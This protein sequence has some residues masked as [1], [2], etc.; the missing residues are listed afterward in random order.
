MR[1]AC[2]HACSSPSADPGGTKH[3]HTHTHPSL[4][5]EPACNPWVPTRRPDAA[6]RTGRAARRQASRTF[7][8]SR[9]ATPPGSNENTERNTRQ[10]PF[11]EGS[12]NRTRK[13]C[14]SS[15]C[16]G[17]RAEPGEAGQRGDAQSRC[18][19]TAGSAAAGRLCRRVRAEPFLTR[20]GSSSARASAQSVEQRERESAPGGSVCVCA[21]T[22]SAFTL[23]RQSLCVRGCTE[24]SGGVRAGGGLWSHSS[25]AGRA[26]MAGSGGAEAGGH[27]PGRGCRAGNFWGFHHLQPGF[28]ECLSSPRL[29][30]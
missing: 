26:E 12:K 1:P 3:A 5:T 17:G 10:K 7:L 9:A 27:G 6:A 18:C 21:H 2:A 13:E 20:T 16:L 22:Q 11:C 23:T 15:A 24:L 30:K 28:A 25:G 19:L 29:L 4:A 14:R 8:R